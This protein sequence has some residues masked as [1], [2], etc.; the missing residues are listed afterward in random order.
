MHLPALLIGVVLI[1]SAGSAVDARAGPAP[2]DDGTYSALAADLEVV[3]RALGIPGM[4]AAVVHGGDLVWAEGFGQADIG[5]GMAATPHT[6]FGLASVTKPVAATLLMQLVEEGRIDLDAPAAD[7]GADVPGSPDATVRH[8][9]THT[10][11]G[12]PG[13]VHQYDGNRYALLGDVMEGATGQTF[14][15]LLGE[16]IVVPL[17]MADTALNPL[18][19]SGRHWW[20]GIEEVRLALGWG[21]AFGHY[22]DVYRRLARPY[23]FDEDYAIVPG[24]YHLTHSPATGL[25][26]S[27]ADLAAFDIA[28]EEGRL[29]GAEAR[30]AMLSPAV[31]T[32]AGRT[33]LSYGLGWYIQQFEGTELVWHS[34]RWPPSTSA[35]YLK[36]P[37]RDVSFFVLANTDN[38]TVPFPGIGD[39]DISRSALFLT[40]FRHLV[41]PALHGTELPSIDWFAGE[42]ALV[43]QLADVAD[44]PARSHVE[45]E[46]W[47]FRRAFAASGDQ[48]RVDG[49]WVVA[50]RALPGSSRRLDASFTALPERSPIVAPVLSAGRVAAV[51]RVV[52]VWLAVVAASMVAMVLRLARSPRAAAWD[53]I[54]WLSAT[55]VAGPVALLVNHLAD[56]H[57]DGGEVPS[58]EQ[59]VCASF[60][61]MTAYAV[62]WAVSLA[63]VMRLGD[64]A[65]GPVVLLLMIVLP[66]VIGLLAV[67]APLLVRWGIVPYRRAVRRGAVAELISWSVAL[68]VLFP[69][70]LVVDEALLST[71]PA[72]TSPYFGTMISLMAA[73]GFLAL[74]P[75]QAL[76][77][78]RGFTIWR[79]LRPTGVATAV[80][81]PTVRDSW[82]LLSATA[83]LGLAIIVLVAGAVV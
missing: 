11:Q 42:D 5:A 38:L 3:R 57:S 76:L 71:I 58:W 8:L 17:G 60:F 22:P 59:A 15:R 7:Y 69:L 49:L 33:D 66:I 21:T 48:E 27:V 74:I 67:R 55:I 32:V 40:A 64:D 43:G 36:V 56:R 65:G 82:W 30:R 34:G 12:V 29:L 53:W 14:A 44:G 6:P 18:G 61:G 50:A 39:G 81:H 46:L 13:T 54:I 52:V 1:V 16:R 20:S 70:S 41:F 31:P 62:A 4:A 63:V 78:R 2:L 19:T 35:L 25:V 83:G 80:Q 23:Q 75:L 28:L 68:A 73:A 9:L 51:A 26:S 47:S 72:A 77:R 37:G 10:S 45:R 24:M 79:G